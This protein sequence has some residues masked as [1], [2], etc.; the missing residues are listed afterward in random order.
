VSTKTRLNVI[1]T[2]I[3]LMSCIWNFGP[4][5]FKY[6][7][8]YIFRTV[9][10][11]QETEFKHGSTG[12]THVLVSHADALATK[13]AKMTQKILEERPTTLLTLILLTWR[14]G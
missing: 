8:P 5:L 1:L 11:N 12:A 9:C 10:M 3:L 14:I 13:G 4:N 7:Y 2:I 6:F